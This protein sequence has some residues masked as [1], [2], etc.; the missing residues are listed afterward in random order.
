MFSY[1]DMT[2]CSASEC[3]NKECNRYLSEFVLE[4][5]RTWGGEDAPIAIS[6]FSQTCTSY[7][8]EEPDV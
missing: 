1:R 5:A 2:F 4:G 3:A 8:P 7:K 6:D